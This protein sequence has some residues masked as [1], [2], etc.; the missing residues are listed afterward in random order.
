MV[1][2]VGGKVKLFWR[3]MNSNSFFWRKLSFNLHSQKEMASWLNWIEH[4]ITAQ[5]VP[6][7][8][9]GE[10]TKS[11]ELNSALFYFSHPSRLFI[12]FSSKNYG[13]RFLNSSIIGR[14][15]S[16]S[17]SKMKTSHF[18]VDPNPD[19]LAASFS[20]FRIDLISASSKISLR[21]LAVISVP[22]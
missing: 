3:S 8:N 11:A 14:A 17:F 1:F 15:F 16:V 22:E 21:I 9:P 2:I 5:E 10:V 12:S 19:N 20:F 4:L 13:F 7:L 18:P 6:G